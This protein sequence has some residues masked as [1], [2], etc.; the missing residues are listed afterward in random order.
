MPSIVL[1]IDPS[2]S[3]TVKAL[4]RESGMGT[5]GTGWLLWMLRYCMMD[6]IEV[7]LNIDACS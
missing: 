5:S 7:I 1:F 3:S 4:R 6:E 2:I